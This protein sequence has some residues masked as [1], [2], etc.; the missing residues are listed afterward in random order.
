MNF[1]FSDEQELLRAE[2]RKFL[3]ESAPIE[4]VRRIGETQEGYSPEQWKQIAELCW[5]GLAMP[6]AYG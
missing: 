3:A 4:E 6:E 1:G 5:T 2:V